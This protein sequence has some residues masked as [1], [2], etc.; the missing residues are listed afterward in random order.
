MHLAAWLGLPVLNLSM[1]PVNAWDTGP[2]Q[3]AHLILRS[4]ISCRGCWQCKSGLACHRHFVPTRVAAII[5]AV[6]SRGVGADAHAYF[7]RL[8]LP[9]QEIMF[10]ARR[11]GLYDLLPARPEAHNSAHALLGNFWRCFFGA[12]F[13]LWEETAPQK[14]WKIL[15]ERAPSLRPSFDR[16]LASLTAEYTRALKTRSELSSDFWRSVPPLL[17]PLSGY[18]HLLLQNGD[19]S[20]ESFLRGA[21]ML[22]FLSAITEN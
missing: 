3:P 18:L 8:R 13:S 6:L 2:V 1:G 4:G 16:A 11:N 19:Y 15:E 5:S 12:G 21:G 7:A 9:G 14:S 22:D 17:R 10:T 20:P